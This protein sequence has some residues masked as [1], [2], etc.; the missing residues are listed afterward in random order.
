MMRRTILIAAVLTMASVMASTAM[1]AEKKTLC[2]YDPSGANGD[3]FQI[4]KDYRT[5]AVGWGIN[6]KLKAYT[7]EKIAAEDFKAGQ[8]DAAVLTGTRARPFQ[9]FTGTIEAIGA[10]P[11]YGHLE[12]VVKTLAS[13]KASRMMKKGDFEI[14]GIFPGGAVYLFVN[15]RGI[16]TV[17]KMAG[18]RLAVLE[19]DTASKVMAA[20]VGASSVG[21][22]I[23]TFAGLFNN[24]NVSMCYSPALAYQALELHKGI[25]SK[26]GV[27]RYP[28]AQVTFQILTRSA[29][30]NPDFMLSSRK[31]AASNFSRF[32]A[33]NKQAESK[34]P[35]SHWIDIPSSDKVRYDTMFQETRIRLRDEKKVYDKTMLRM[36]RKIRCKVDGSRAECT[37]NKE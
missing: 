10:L 7:D 25:G 12:K 31:W 22:D 29:A 20:H 27:I 32:L 15:D 6:F 14:A 8:C 30:F 18:K 16:N 36:M 4:M 26:G 9:R 28:L 3:A 33:L 21:A 17:E 34:I 1:A 11:T 35:S 13:P 2:V 5:A 19:Y 24:K 23:A 37:T